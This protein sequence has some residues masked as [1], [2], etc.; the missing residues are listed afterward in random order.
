[1]SKIVAMTPRDNEEPFFPDNELSKKEEK[2][3][4]S[5][6]IGILRFSES[7]AKKGLKSFITN[8]DLP[9]ATPYR[10]PREHQSLIKPVKTE[11]LL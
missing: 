7:N 10:T 4:E 9:V 6:R 2:L 5:A 1:M 11:R 3:V 8:Y